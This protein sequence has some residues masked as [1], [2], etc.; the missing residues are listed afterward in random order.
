MDRLLTGLA[1][2]QNG[3]ALGAVSLVTSA[4]LATSDHVMQAEPIP[5]ADIS[6]MRFVGGGTTIVAHQVPGHGSIGGSAAVGGSGSGS[7]D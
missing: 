1:S 7:G 5:L 6:A 2:L 4:A 3:A